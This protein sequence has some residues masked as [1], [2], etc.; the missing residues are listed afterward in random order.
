MFVSPR[1]RHERVRRI[2]ITYFMADGTKVEVGFAEVGENETVMHGTI[3]DPRVQE[4]ISRGTTTH[5]SIHTD[6]EKEREALI[7]AEEPYDRLA[8]DFGLE[9]TH[10]REERHIPDHDEVR[11]PKQG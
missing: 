4:I 11:K 6:G 7:V 8:R 2:P 10:P 9:I 5:L 1:E 3:F